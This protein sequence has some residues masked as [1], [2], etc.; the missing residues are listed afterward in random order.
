MILFIDACVRK[1]SR[2]K[3]LAE[4]LLERL[5]GEICHLK[6]E[7]CSFPLLD[8]A[9]LEKRDALIAAGAFDD[10]MFAYARQFAAADEI[11]IAAP[12]WD[13]SFPAVLKQYIEHI[14]VVGITFE[15]SPE[16]IPQGLCRASRIWYVSTAG[17]D[18]APSTYGFGYIKA[19]AQDYYG[20][21]DIRL[22]EATGL[23][24]IGADV[25]VI[26]RDAVDKIN[27]GTVCRQ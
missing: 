23:D 25:E 10:D 19:L 8:G 5:D 17:G 24:I 14:N 27:E 13:Y 21:S 9:L 7:E 22:L 16:G 26:L 1:D 20:I 6:L 15:Y 11:V 18:W 12:Y 3:R 2:T 4:A